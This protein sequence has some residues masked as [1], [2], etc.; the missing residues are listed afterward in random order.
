MQ[1][2]NNLCKLYILFDLGKENIFYQFNVILEMCIIGCFLKLD[3]I[4][5]NIYFE[6]Y[7]YN[8]AMKN[9]SIALTLGILL[10]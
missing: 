7:C 1:K 6:I 8:F 2:Y 10:K 3:G 5:V 9:K 4:L